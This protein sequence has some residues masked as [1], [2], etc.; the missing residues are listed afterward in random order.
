[1]KRFLTTM[2]GLAGLLF[3]SACEEAP[4]AAGHAATGGWLSDLETAKKES[5]ASNKPILIDF[6]AEW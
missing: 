5:K 2:A 4:G 6:G 1:M 3:I